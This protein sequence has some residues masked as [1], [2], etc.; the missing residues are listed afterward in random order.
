M[1]LV[2][3]YE[4]VGDCAIIKMAPGGWGEEGEI[5]LLDAVQGDEFSGGEDRDALV[6]AQFF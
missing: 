3:R 5:D 4:E 6:G 2:Q 1:W